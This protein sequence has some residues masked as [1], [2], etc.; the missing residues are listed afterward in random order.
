MMMEIVRAQ[1]FMYRPMTV[2]LNVRNMNKV[3]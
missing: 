2:I 3:S 1:I